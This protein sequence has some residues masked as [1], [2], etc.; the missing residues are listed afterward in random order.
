MAR[1]RHLYETEVAEFNR[2][3]ELG[4][5][6]DAATFEWRGPRRSEPF[7]VLF[8]LPMMGVFGGVADV[9]ELTN[10][11]VLEGLHAG[12]V[13]LEEA[14]SEIDLELF[15][16]PL[17]LAARTLRRGAPG[18]PGARRHRLPDGADGRARGR[19]PAGDEDRLLPAGLRGLVRRRPGRG[20]GADLRPG[21]ADDRDLDLAR[22]RDRAPARASRRGGADERRP[23]GLLPA[24]RPLRESARSASSR[25][26]ATRSGA[27]FAISCRRC[28]P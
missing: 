8:V 17:R 6:R 3:D 26:C 21:A 24:R 10:A 18:D 23:G 20:G 9:L 4:A 2:R 14:A 22:G 19:A 16:T 27:A 11:L 25:C 28:A 13:L 5:L 12:V 1:W 15:F 7:D